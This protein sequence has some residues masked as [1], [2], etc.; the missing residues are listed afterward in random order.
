MTQRVVTIEEARD[1]AKRQRGRD[2]ADRRKDEAE[3]KAARRERLRLSTEPVSVRLPFPPSINRYWRT[4]VVG[5]SI[6]EASVITY[7][8]AAGTAY[9]KEVIRLWQKVGVTFEGKLA[10]KV[11]VVMPDRRERDLDGLWKALLDSLEHAGACERDSQIKAES[12][13]E[14]AIESPG[15]I[16][17]VLGPKP[18]ER[19]GTLFDTEW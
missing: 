8:S 12:M 9:R 10:I 3:A 15:W 16:E 1:L 5:K 18:G 13:E 4:K 19:Q 7:I 2:W 17:I 11:R 6:R 14:V